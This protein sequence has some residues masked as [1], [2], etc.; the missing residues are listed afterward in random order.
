MVLQILFI[1]IFC[2][3]LQKQREQSLSQQ[4]QVDSFFF[5]LQHLTIRV[6]E[7]WA[8]SEIP[9][10]VGNQMQKQGRNK[11]RMGEGVKGK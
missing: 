1:E 10:A 5:L 8:Q 9:R 2:I 4:I 3:V 11:E 6:L 7:G